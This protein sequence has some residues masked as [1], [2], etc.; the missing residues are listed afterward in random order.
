M[1]AHLCKLA[2]VSK[3]G[4][5]KWIN[6]TDN[7]YLA[8]KK[9]EQD[10]ALIEKVF[11]L[12]NKKAGAKTIKMELGNDEGIIMN[13]KKIHRLM[14]KYGLVAKVRQAN[15]YK[16][17]AQATQ[18]HKT[19]PNIVNREFD[20]GEPGKVLLTD[21]TYLYYGN[22]QVGYLSA[23]KDGSTNEILAHHVSTSLKMGLVYSTL[24]NLIENGFE[25]PAESYLHSDQGMHYTHPI[26]QHKVRQLGFTQSMSRRGNCWDNA[27][28]E[29]FFG[30]LKDEVDIKG[31]QSIS[32]LKALINEYILDYNT[33]RY[34][35]DLKKMTPNQYRDHLLV[36]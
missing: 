13:L 9:D 7:R 28:I 24:D 3:S 27:P 1:T 14:N 26:F 5:Y 22:G 15:P 30:H 10:F 16:K 33:S 20:T 6:N 29:S 11:L 12:K 32:A 25:L 36:A 21:I 23:I 34:Q 19:C 31:C 2:N 18:E 17:L 4:Y 8:E 35:W